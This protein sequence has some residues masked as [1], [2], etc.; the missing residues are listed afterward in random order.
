MQHIS[1]VIVHYNNS[2]VTSRC[3][4][5]LSKLATKG[6]GYSVI[7]VDNGSKKPYTL[8]RTL[9]PS[10]FLVVRSEQNLGFTGGNNIGIKHAI[11]QKNSSHVALLNN[12]TTVHRQLLVKLLTAFDE[13]PGA[14]IICPLIYFTKGQEFHSGYTQAERGKV[15]W[16][17]GG[18]IDWPNVLAFHRGVD[19]VDR[20]QCVALQPVD[21]ATGCC[22]AIKREV[23]EKTG[24]LDP[25]YFLYLED[26]AFSLLAKKYGYE[27]YLQPSAI[28]WH[29]N[30]GS[31]G[32]ASPTQRY[33]FTRNR[34]YFGLQH[35]KWRRKMT[36]L[37]FAIRQLYGGAQYER[38]GA[39]HALIGRMGKYTVV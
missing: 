1:L 24:G 32:I 26:V 3:L 38:L 13:R 22:M 16:Y 15:I 2:A 39:L 17:A 18:S 4:R 21:Y 33:Y 28:V 23:L 11:E 34:I 30:A 19:E 36:T 6:F 9:S 27:L 29:D 31:S 5:S 25:Q 12:D 20:G 37:S 7:I 10:R 14:G 35:G 8:P